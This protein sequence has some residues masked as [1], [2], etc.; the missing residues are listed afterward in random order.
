MIK[1]ILP[2]FSTDPFLP[3]KFEY[4]VKIRQIILKQLFHECQDSKIV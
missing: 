1:I 2:P 4:N 3:L